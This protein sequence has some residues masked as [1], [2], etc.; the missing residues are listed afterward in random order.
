MDGST[1]ALL[2]MAIGGRR[3]DIYFSHPN[4]EATDELVLDLI[5]QGKDVIIVDL[6]ISLSLAE[7]LNERKASIQLWDHHKSAIPLDKF[8]WC[9]IEKENQKCGCRMFYDYTLTSEIA[10][11]G[12]PAY[13][14]LVM[15]ADD[16]D[17]WIKQ[18][19]PETDDIASLHW[20]LGQK[21]FMD[22][23][24]ADPST[25]L[26]SEEKYLLSIEEQKKKEFIERKEKEAL[27]Y[28]VTIDGQNYEVAVVEANSNQSQLGHYLCETSALFADFA[29]MIGTKG[30]SFRK[31]S[32][33]PVDLSVLAKQFGGGGHEAAAGASVANVLGEEFVDLVWGK[34]MKRLANSIRSTNI[35]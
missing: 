20:L 22:R 14:D 5:S 3:E 8:D 28:P 10:L 31:K 12:L 1:S 24:A 32:S 21:L 2:W 17:R 19:N 29:V 30:I 23:F 4:H 33:C 18:Y 15:L 26:S 9:F 13:K 35:C 6:S 27:L 34:I 16:Y 11:R 7:Q 25:I